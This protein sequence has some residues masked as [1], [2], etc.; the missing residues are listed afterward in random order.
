MNE[1]NEAFLNSMVFLLNKIPGQHICN[2]SR[3]YGLKEN[4]AMCQVVFSMD[5]SISE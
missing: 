3:L 5:L 4:I 1:V 2:K